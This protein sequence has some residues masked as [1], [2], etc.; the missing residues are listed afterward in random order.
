MEISTNQSGNITILCLSGRLDLTAG[1]VLKETVMKSLENGS[2][3]I[4]L[5]LEKIDFIN[6]SGLGA[7]VSVMKEIRIRHGRMTLSN[8]AAYVNEIFE[9]TQLTHIFEI[10]PTQEEAIKS[11]E[12][13]ATTQS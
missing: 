10:F 8:L 11:F 3:K 6:S 12:K 2:G 7:M 5:N 1:V 13:V 4:H 9:I